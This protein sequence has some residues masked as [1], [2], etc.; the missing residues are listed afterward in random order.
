MYIRRYF[1][2]VDG[3]H[4]ILDESED[5]QYY[6]LSN[7]Y[8]ANQ[9]LGNVV[10]LEINSNTCIIDDVKLEL[11]DIGTKYSDY[12]DNNIVY[13]K[14]LPEYLWD[15]CYENSVSGNL[16]FSL[17]ED[18]P[19]VCSDGFS[20]LCNADEA[21]CNIYTNVKD[22]DDQV[23]AQVSIQDYCPEE[24]NNYDLYIGAKDYFNSTRGA[25]FIPET[26]NTCSATDIGCTEFTNL[27][28]LNSG[29]EAKEYYT[30][31]KQ[32]I[33]PS[34]N[35][36]AAFYVWQGS[37]NG[38]YQL[39]SYILKKAEDTN[40]P[41]VVEMMPVFVM[42]IYIIYLLLILIIILIV[43][44]FITLMVKFPIIYIQNNNLFMK[45]VILISN[46]QENIE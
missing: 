8:S 21:G 38:S 29:G 46:V 33:K 15:D 3:K 36:C 26:A 6:R 5:W 22:R 43:I 9:F 27:D 25:K 34:E 44:N 16:D 39:E 30:S 41:A 42:K 13:Q 37:N 32:C 12:G 10:G 11:G 18:A 17:Q 45:I 14:M 24:C 4:D 28:I 20:R 19:A 1:G 2:F 23:I 35:D 31:L 40:E 7:T